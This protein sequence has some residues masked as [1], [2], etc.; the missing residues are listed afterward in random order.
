VFHPVDANTFIY[1]PWASVVRRAI[2]FY[3]IALGKARFGLIEGHSWAHM[4]NV[5]Q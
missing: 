4:C 2:G 3:F 1:V 5:L